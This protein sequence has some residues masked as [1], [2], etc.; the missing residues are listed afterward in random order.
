[1][2]DIKV[3]VDQYIQDVQSGK[4]IACKWEK[5]AVKR[6]LDDLE[7]QNT[8]DFPYHFDETRASHPILFTHYYCVHVKGPL[9][10]Q[11]LILEPWQQF[12]VWVL[13]GWLDQEDKRRFRIAFI[14]VAKKNGKSTM[15]AALGLY[16]LVID[17]EGGSEVYSA[18]TTK[19]QAKIVFYEYARAM[20]I[21]NPELQELFKTYKHSIVDAET[22]TSTFTA[23]ASDV[24]QL[25]G[26]NVHCAI[27]DEY[28]AHKTDGVFRIMVDGM[29]ARAQPMTINITTAGFDPE[30]PCV[31]EEEY[32]QRVL[33][34]KAKNETYFGIVFTLDEDDDWT[35]KS[36]WS[37]A[38]PCLGVSKQLKAMEADFDKALAMPTEQNKFKNKNLNIWTKNKTGWLKNED[39]QKAEKHFDLQ[40]MA[41]MTCFA[42]I[43]LAT[44]GDTAS[45][46]L[47]F[48]WED[49]YRLYDRIFLPEDDIR[50]RELRERFEWQQMADQGHVILTP[51]RTIDYDF[52]QTR[53]LED[54]ATFDL[55]E[56]AYDP[57]N[58]SQ[59]INNLE[60]EGLEKKLVEF[61]QGWKYMSPATK[62]F[63]TKLK[64][65]QLESF[66]NPV[67]AWMVSNAVTKTDSNGNTRVVKSS[68][69][70]H[71]DA[72]VSKIIAL[73]RAVRNKKQ[74]SVYEERGAIVI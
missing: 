24:D 39:W 55:Q 60:K 69:R 53:I 35:D 13:F 4:R 36:K 42:G 15:V 29:S 59:F 72:V 11:P 63:E 28:H 37:K 41:G 51:T 17:G 32:C 21:K 9:D 71:I 26:K 68:P 25:D 46:T 23:V 44:V 54:A 57:Y 18:A 58:A 43:D 66:Q 27:I 6:H 22:E 1:M 5:L 19:D 31:D 61:P 30:V 20:V 38:N 74:K 34:G 48:P 3:T 52:I 45:Y 47:C 70:K 7:R 14:E 10:R 64:N 50:E 8:P 67:V 33:S 49:S 2:N 62:D 16:M 73:D 40:E 56:I 12:I 65:G